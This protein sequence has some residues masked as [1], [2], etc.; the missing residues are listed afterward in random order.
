MST[1]RVTGKP[2]ASP[3]PILE[4]REIGDTFD[5]ELDKE[6]EQHLVTA[7]A[8]APVESAKE[9]RSSERATIDKGEEPRRLRG[10]RQH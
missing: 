5:A 10:S 9:E 7:G 2:L 3:A 6:T 1:Y 8:L 4:G